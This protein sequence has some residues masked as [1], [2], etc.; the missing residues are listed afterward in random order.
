[1]VRGERGR[2]R[3]L[4]KRATM[5]DEML[6]MIFQLIMVVFIGLMVFTY[7]NNKASDI[8]FEK[9]LIA[10]D[11][12]LLTTAMY[13]SPGN[14]VYP[15]EPS[16]TLS[17]DEI[18]LLV[19]LEQTRVF[20]KQSDRP[21][22][23]PAWYYY[24]RDR[25]VPPFALQDYSYGSD[26]KFYRFGYD[27]ETDISNTNYNK[28]TCPS[29]AR[30]IDEENTDDPSWISGETI[31][32]DVTPE[33]TPGTYSV[34]ENQVGSRLKTIL[35]NK[36]RF[37]MTD[38]P[39][40][41]TVQIGI[42]LQQEADVSAIRAY[43][44]DSDPRLEESRSLA[45]SLINEFLTPQTFVKYVQVV[46]VRNSTNKT[47][48][49]M[50]TKNPEASNVRVV[51]ELGVVDERQ[52]DF[53][54]SANAIYNA[55]ARFFGNKIRLAT[56]GPT[57]LPNFIQGQTPPT[58]PPAGA[59]SPVC[60]G[61]SDEVKDF[62][63]KEEA[64]LTS[65]HQ[66]GGRLWIPAEAN[67]PGTYP[68]IIFL[69]GIRPGAMHSGLSNDGNDLIAEGKKALQS[70]KARPFLLGGPSHVHPD[71]AK[72]TTLFPGFSVDEFVDAV[73]SYALNDGMNI[74]EV[75]V[76][77]HSGAGCNFN[78]GIHSAAESS[79]V[80]MIVQLDTCMDEARGKD[81][82][83]KLKSSTKFVS[84]FLPVDW[85][86]DQ[87]RQALKP[88]STGWDEMNDALGINKDFQCFSFNYESARF[89]GC[90]S[91]GVNRY[92]LPVHGLTGGTDGSAHNRIRRL[93][94]HF[95]LQQFLP[96]S[97]AVASASPTP[98]TSSGTTTASLPTGSVPSGSS[99]TVGPPG[100]EVQLTEGAEGIYTLAMK[101]GDPYVRAFMR[102]LTVGEGTKGPTKSCPDPYRIF[103][104][105]SCLEGYTHT[106]KA[107][108]AGKYTS[109]AAGRY[110]FLGNI[111]KSFATKAGIPV[112]EFTPQNQ[113]KIIYD[114]LMRRGLDKTLQAGNLDQALQKT[115]K[116]W[117][118]L[119]GSSYGQ[120]TTGRANWERHYK[121]MLA[122]EQAMAGGVA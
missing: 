115:N 119:P 105:G 21:Q 23:N 97:L 76:I 104:G 42:R 75:Y 88:D 5:R 13:S 92:S 73:K 83:N 45:C 107:I 103:Y 59:P 91:N 95:I 82:N 32:I 12:G 68:L 85:G 53:D 78:G 61:K 121:A 6:Y 35:Q 51:L 54:N 87:G 28:I 26:L 120:P 113:D 46:P 40:Q 84:L 90:R 65:G 11:M 96:P 110:Q 10:Q 118:S 74:G 19:S 22:F 30:D 69:H 44:L 47:F 16:V 77:G 52:I 64:Y 7:I 43:V 112:E 111:W 50:L 20:V 101:G 71:A 3:V 93:A 62:P 114:E 39:L 67:C 1:M 117:A 57:I 31:Y 116:V 25:S 2:A 36:Q 27:L 102:A 122:E 60:S 41:S 49:E 63:F 18:Q 108:T 100:Q 58:A 79:N 66:N 9:R 48:L 109:S 106:M 89:E 99:I 70:G 15:Y 72:G 38:D 81:L 24:A 98:S 4:F 14:F 34:Q 94:I 17:D 80:N 8:G 33:G 55:L 86:R 37:T 29:I 56:T